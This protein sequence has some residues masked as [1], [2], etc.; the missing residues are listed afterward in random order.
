MISIG[1]IV[2]ASV[3]VLMYFVGKQRNSYRLKQAGRISVIVAIL[4][5][6]LPR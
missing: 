5:A 2:V 3:G 1:S 4:H 6:V